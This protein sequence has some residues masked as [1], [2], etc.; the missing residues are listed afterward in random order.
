MLAAELRQYVHSS[1]PHAQ[2][3]LTV[4]SGCLVAQARG[5]CLTAVACCATPTL[6]TQILIAAAVV[7]FIIAAS[8]GES[9]LRCVVAGPS[10]HMPLSLTPRTAAT[11]GAAATHTPEQSS[12]CLCR[13]YG[14]CW[15]IGTWSCM[16]V[17]CMLCMRC[18]LCGCP[19]V[20]VSSPWSLC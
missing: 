7:D 3:K 14:P 17:L 19:A 4:Q 8:S 15:H 6:P 20:P 5:K 13:R 18:V 9:F 16:P 11:A 2:T 12:S 1:G 10:H